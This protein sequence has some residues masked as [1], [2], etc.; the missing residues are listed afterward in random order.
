MAIL[1]GTMTIKPC[2][3]K[4]EREPQIAFLGPI[5]SAATRQRNHPVPFPAYATS[6]PWAIGLQVSSKKPYARVQDMPEE[7]IEWAQV[8]D[9][10]DYLTELARDK[11]N[12]LWRQIDTYLFS[13]ESYHDVAVAYCIAYSE[14]V[15]ANIKLST[16]NPVL[17]MNG[18]LVM[19]P[20]TDVRDR[21]WQ[22]MQ[23]CAQKLHLHVPSRWADYVG[24]LSDDVET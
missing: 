21:A 4:M 17:M 1:Y 14:F 18:R 15:Q 13:P 19:N 6:P 23:E 12:S 8:P 3:W 22:T 20:Y 16:S 2:S 10:P 9:P 11:W 5:E 7:K 24:A